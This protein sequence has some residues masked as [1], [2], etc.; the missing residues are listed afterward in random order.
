M[1]IPTIRGTKRWRAFMS[2]IA[3]RILNKAQGQRL[4]DDMMAVDALI[5]MFDQ[6]SMGARS[7]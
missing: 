1:S 6:P 5:H 7:P 3:G 2:I 4:Q